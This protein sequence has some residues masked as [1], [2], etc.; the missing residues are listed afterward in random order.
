[1][2]CIQWVLMALF[3][4]GMDPKFNFL[5]ET[6]YRD[7]I[8][9]DKNYHIGTY[10]FLAIAVI[11]LVALFLPDKSKAQKVSLVTCLLGSAMLLFNAI[12]ALADL[13]FHHDE[14]SSES[15]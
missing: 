7:G 2:N 5:R 9:N 3:N 4:W 15:E 8:F 11:N 10:V 14:P 12:L 1:M 6:G 13:Y